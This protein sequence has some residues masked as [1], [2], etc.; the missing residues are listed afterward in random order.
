VD[1]SLEEVAHRLRTS[2]ESHGATVKQHTRYPGWKATP[3]SRFN[4]YVKERYEALLGA[5]VVLKAFHAGLECGVFKGVAPE[6]EMVSLGPTL[7]G[8]HTPEEAIDVASV[9][10]LWGV[11]RSIVG[12]MDKVEGAI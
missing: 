3:R 6:L 4:L 1:A 7:R 9:R 2:G 5:P 11:L 10:T 8:V 12:G